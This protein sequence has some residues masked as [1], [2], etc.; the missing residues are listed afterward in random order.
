MSVNCEFTC[1]CWTLLYWC[2]AMFTISRVVFFGGMVQYVCMHWQWPVAS[3]QKNFNTTNTTMSLHMP[4][5]W[6]TLQSSWPSDGIPVLYR[7]EIGSNFIFGKLLHTIVNCFGFRLRFPASF[8][9]LRSLKPPAACH[10]FI[11]KSLFH[12]CVRETNAHWCLSRETSS[13]TASCPWKIYFL[14][15]PRHF[16]IVQR[17]IWKWLMT[18]ACS[19]PRMLLLQLQDSDQGLFM[20][21]SSNWRWIFR[22]YILSTIQ[23]TWQRWYCIAKLLHS[24]DV[25][26]LTVTWSWWWA[27]STVYFAMFLCCGSSAPWL[28]LLQDSRGTNSQPYLPWQLSQRLIHKAVCSGLG[29]T[30]LPTW[31]WNRDL[32]VSKSWYRDTRERANAKMANRRLWHRE[33]PSVANFV[34]QL[35]SIWW[36]T[37]LCA[38]RKTLISNQRVIPIPMQT[39]FCCR[40]LIARH[41]A[42]G[43]HERALQGNANFGF[44][45]QGQI[46]LACNFAMK[47]WSFHRGLSQIIL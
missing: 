45:S 42:L 23:K 22:I 35:R 32:K 9:W 17:E 13:K 39:C 3:G 29:E 21:A 4:A 37:H 14:A 44:L 36:Q 18:T 47:V 33:T 25:S 6:L 10:L 12:R 1:L 2:S 43:S 5:G 40:W 46:L 28:G 31:P 19:R 26:W 8:S 34:M 15:R 38:A 16:P 20:W 11:L 41:G 7:S 24:K 27:T 30:F